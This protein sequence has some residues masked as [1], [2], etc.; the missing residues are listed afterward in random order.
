M[1]RNN[2]KQGQEIQGIPD[3]VE[4][5][6][7]EPQLPSG[8]RA[9]GSMY[10]EVFLLSMVVVAVHL[11]PFSGVIGWRLFAGSGSGRIAALFSF[12]AAFLLTVRVFF[13]YNVLIE[14]AGARPSRRTWMVEV[15]GAV[16]FLAWL[17]P[18]YAVTHAI[19][20]ASIASLGICVSILISAVVSRRPGADSHF[21]HDVASVVVVAFAF[22][23][24]YCI[25][26]I[27]GSRGEDFLGA[28]AIGSSSFHSWRTVLEAVSRSRG[29]H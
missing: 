27:S 12:L 6:K 16:V 5:V 9:R 24:C 29:R 19:A 8:A 3:V 4:K 28:V 7:G 15:V 13:H 25:P 20:E 21:L 10:I 14:E 26:S 23:W 22:G 18:V 17:A 1:Y 2:D 11:L